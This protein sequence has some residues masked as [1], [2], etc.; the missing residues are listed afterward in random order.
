L[1]LTK[2]DPPYD[3]DLMD[4]MKW[5]TNE[6]LTITG[7]PRSWIME[8]GTENRGVTEAEQRPFDVRI[9]AIHRNILEPQINRLLL[10]ALGYYKKAKEAENY[11]V[12]RF[13]EISKKGEK[14]I[15]QNVAMLQSFGLKPKALVKYLD[16]RGIL[17]LDETDFQDPMMLQ[18]A[19]IPGGKPKDL[20]PSR[21]RMDK[22]MSDM[23]Q[24]RNEAGTSDS[25]AAKIE[26]QA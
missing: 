21:Q 19:G 10:P 24:N 8:S 4:I 18:N 12:F 16:E 14:E 9:Q 20:Y 13:N 5:L 26:A 22:S 3:K 15:L 11:V 7:V 17:G 6:V 2:V 25:G 23:T 1:Q